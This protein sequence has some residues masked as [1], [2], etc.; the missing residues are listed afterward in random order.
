MQ[1][2]NAE[3]PCRRGRRC[4]AR[5]AFRI[6]RPQRSCRTACCKATVNIPSVRYRESCHSLRFLS[7]KVS[8]SGR[9]RC[10]VPPPPGRECWFSCVRVSIRTCRVS[11]YFS[12]LNPSLGFMYRTRKHSHVPRFRAFFCFWSRSCSAVPF[13]CP[14]RKHAHVPRFRAFF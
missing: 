2:E 12:S 9:A 8:R 13:V 14:T 1:N 7:S 5:S 3:D 10:A 6:R 4:F 11:V